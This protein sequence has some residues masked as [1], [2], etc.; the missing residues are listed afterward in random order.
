[1]KNDA[2]LVK[3]EYPPFSVAMSVYKNDNPIFFDRA[4]QS[5]TENQKVMP[6]EIVIIVDGPVDEKI[7]AVIE[8][9]SEKYGNLNVIRLDKNAGL[10]NALKLAIENAKYELIARMDS[11]DVSA[12]NRFEQQLEIMTKNSAVD[13]VGGDISE[14]IG[15]EN[16]IVA[17]RKVPIL[18]KEIKEYLKTR[19]PF[20]H[21]TVMYKRSA[22]LKS[23]NYIDLFYN[24]DYWLWIRMVENNC[25]MANT[26]T[27][28]VNA[29]VGEDM[30]KR[31]GGKQ[32]FNSEMFLQKYMLKNGIINLPTF[33]LNSSKRFVVQM[34]LPNAIR[35]WVFKTFARTK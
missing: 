6:T 26:G 1:M 11:D 34:L 19:C 22:V 7:N 35:E 24:E 31:R 13:I 14:F 28:L 18:D 15:D 23:G 30:Y 32:Y 5:I 27:I 4:L 3:N 9:Y 25:I 2:D 17:K 21:M 12:P 29:R 10:G 33:V 8:K 20:N 16:N